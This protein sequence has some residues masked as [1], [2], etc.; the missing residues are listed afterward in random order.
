MDNDDVNNNNFRVMFKKIYD[1][2]Y[3]YKKYCVDNNKKYDIIIRTRPDIITSKPLTQ[4]DINIGKSGVLCMTWIVG[5]FHILHIKKYVS[6]M[7]FF[8]NDETALSI[9]LKGP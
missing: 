8:S 7:F 9:S 3:V 2:H 6:D 1:L 5:L 4:K